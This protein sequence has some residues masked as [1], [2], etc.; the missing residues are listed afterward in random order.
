M[1]RVRASLQRCRRAVLS[2]AFQAL[3]GARALTGTPEGMP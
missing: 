2:A 3:R 1:F